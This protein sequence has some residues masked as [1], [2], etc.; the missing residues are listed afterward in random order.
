MAEVGELIR[1]TCAGQRQKTLGLVL[2]RIYAE[3]REWTASSLNTNPFKGGWVI[4]VHW[5]QKGEYLPKSANDLRWYTEDKRLTQFTSHPWY[6]EKDH[7][8]VVRN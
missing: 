5:L 7:F 8:E 6:H 1:Y 3:P 4:Q 2:K